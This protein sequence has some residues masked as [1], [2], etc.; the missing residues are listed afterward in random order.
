MRKSREAKAQSHQAIVAKAS[1]MFRERGIEGT[2]LGDVMQAASLTHGGFYRHFDSKE[3]LMIAALE[4]AFTDV[5]ET[6]ETGLSATP[7]PRALAEFVAYYL[8]P[9]MVGGAGEGCPVAALSG[10]V[11]RSSD[12]LKAVFGRGAQKIIAVMASSIDGPEDARMR[13]AARTFAMAAGAVMIARASDPQTAALVLDAA[14]QDAGLP[15]EDEPC[16]LSQ[17]R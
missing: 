1:Q 6:I 14:R 15:R 10:D 11:F 17:D 3:A 5:L 12:A 9:K 13:I 8:S 16:S 2:S 7:R 4:S